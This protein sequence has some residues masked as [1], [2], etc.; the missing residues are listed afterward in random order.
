[1]PRYFFNFER[2]GSLTADLIG[3]DLRDDEAAKNE[4]LKLAADVG[5]DDALQGEWPRFDWLE[6]LDEQQRAV[7]RI[8]VADAIR[9]PT[10]LE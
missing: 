7:A 3:R 4:A 1:M 2:A 8:P 10:R 5:T 9:E 6:V